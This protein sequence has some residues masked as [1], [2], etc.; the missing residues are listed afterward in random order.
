MFPRE[1]SFC[2]YINYAYICTCR[3]RHLKESVPWSNIT[4][5]EMGKQNIQTK[6]VHFTFPRDQRYIIVLQ[7]RDHTK[8]FTSGRYVFPLPFLC[9]S[10]RAET[11]QALFPT[12]REGKM[13]KDDGKC[14][15]CLK[16]IMYDMLSF[17]FPAD[18]LSQ[19]FFEGLCYKTCFVHARFP[20]QMLLWSV[21]S[22]PSDVVAVVI[23]L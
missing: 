2:F 16:N 9:L 15:N 14:L 7:R 8:W 19:C 22:G 3:W 18:L 17:L 1:F 20:W 11:S 23:D 6:E 4:W 21:T 10:D 12:L 5:S 13:E